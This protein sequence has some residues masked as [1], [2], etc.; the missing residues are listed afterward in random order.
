MIAKPRQQHRKCKI[1]FASVYLIS[2]KT[3]LFCAFPVLSYDGS[4]CH[5]N[6]VSNY[7]YGHTRALARVDT[8]ECPF[9]CSMALRLRDRRGGGGGGGGVP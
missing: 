9:Q 1:E 7:K 5:F 6:T 8:K 2:T 3:L 4:V